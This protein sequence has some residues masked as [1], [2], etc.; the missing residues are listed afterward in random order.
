MTRDKRL[1]G[2]TGGNQTET[3]DPGRGWR[4]RLRYA[5]GT[6]DELDCVPEATRAEVLARYPGAKVAAVEPDAPDLQ[7]GTGD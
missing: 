5:D 7:G 2:E 1:K 4:W 3:P 6:L